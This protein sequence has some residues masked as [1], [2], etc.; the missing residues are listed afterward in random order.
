MR[1]ND[2]P[3]IESD[4]FSSERK[5]QSTAEQQMRVTRS[6]YYLIT[7]YAALSPGGKAWLVVGVDGKG[8]LPQIIRWKGPDEGTDIGPEMTSTSVEWIDEGETIVAQ[9]TLGDSLSLELAFIS[10]VRE[11]IPDPAVSSV[12]WTRVT[13]DTEPFNPTE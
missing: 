1:Y 13:F 12:S 6:R 9:N 3:L 8:P 4:L 2:D 7:A 5:V 11:P 10:P